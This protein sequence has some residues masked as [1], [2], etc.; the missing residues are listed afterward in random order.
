M[1]DRHRHS[2]MT[3]EELKAR[4]R[5]VR[6][7]HGVTVAIFAVI[8][9]AWIVMGF[10]SRNLPVFITTVAMALTISTIMIPTR[11][12]LSAELKRREG[13]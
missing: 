5:T 7:V 9:L 6:R 13:S 2:D 12:R 4:L 10:W 11:Q 8:I 3:T 1:A